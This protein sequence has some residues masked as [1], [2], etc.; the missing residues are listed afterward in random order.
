MNKSTET[1]IRKAIETLG[2]V[3]YRKLATKAGVSVDTVSRYYQTLKSD[4]QK[5]DTEIVHSKIGH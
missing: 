2:D 1:K 4:T 3:S 5:S